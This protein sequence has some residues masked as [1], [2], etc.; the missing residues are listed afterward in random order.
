MI[1]VCLFPTLGGQSRI[2]VI[3]AVP[4][5]EWYRGR[6]TWASNRALPVVGAIGILAALLSLARFF[7]FANR[8][9]AN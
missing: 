9:V 2:Q 5:E 8:R 6:A 4:A 3:H 7:L 1:P